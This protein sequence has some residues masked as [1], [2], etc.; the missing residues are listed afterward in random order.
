VINSIVAAIRKQRLA[1]SF[2]VII[3]LFLV[4][5]GHAPLLPVI[6]GCVLAIGISTLRSATKKPGSVLTRPGR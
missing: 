1:W 5:V 4:L 3:G 6:A 2:A